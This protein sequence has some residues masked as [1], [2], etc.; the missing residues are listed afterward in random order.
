MFLVCLRWWFIFYLTLYSCGR[1]HAARGKQN[2][3]PNRKESKKDKKE[4]G[5]DKS[6]NGLLRPDFRR[7]D[8]MY[9][10]ANQIQTDT[11]Q[12]YV[13]RSQ[14][15]TNN[16]HT[17]HPSNVIIDWEKTTLCANWRIVFTSKI[18]KIMIKLHIHILYSITHT[19][20]D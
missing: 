3:K 9:N 6:S 19:C 17:T 2:K 20:H 5:S 11:T 13:N 16:N 18:P 15:K 7:V 8:I 14:T 10:L 12:T 1:E 4:G